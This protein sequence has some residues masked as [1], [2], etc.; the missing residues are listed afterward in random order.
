MLFLSKEITT[1]YKDL[2]EVFERFYPFRLIYFSEDLDDQMVE[3]FM[4]R[5]QAGTD[6]DN[7]VM[8][9]SF[10]DTARVLS[11][12]G[13]LL[14]VGLSYGVEDMPGYI[15]LPYNFEYKDLEEYFKQNGLK[16]IRL[17]KRLLDE[18]KALREVLK[19]YDQIGLENI[20]I[21]CL[22]SSRSL[23]D[24][25][26]TKK[27]PL[28]DRIQRSSITLK[29]LLKI[30]KTIQLTNQTLKSLSLTIDYKETQTLLTQTPSITSITIG[31]SFDQEHALSTLSK[32]TPIL[33]YI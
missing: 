23:T 22:D 33:N 12:A 32:L 6:G 17:K 15:S 10:E 31:H 29:R 27:I 16:A 8:M 4:L 18:H 2:Y 11:R 7:E 1:K 5:V 24:D 28:I 14:N 25:L 9:I 21:L 19:E 20:S 30:L 26:N 3:E 13:V